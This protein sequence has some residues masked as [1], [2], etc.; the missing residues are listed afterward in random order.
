MDPVQSE[1]RKE[2]QLERIVYFSDAVFAIAITLLTLEIKIPEIRENISDRALGKALVELLPK[3]AGF[4]FSYLMIGLYWSVHHRIFGY[5]THP[6]PKLLRLNLFFLFFI[7]LMPFSTGFYGDYMGGELFTAQLKIPMT[8][9]AL[10]LTFVG[11]SN[12]FLWSYISNPKNKLI[13][14]P[15]DPYTLHMS[16]ARS[17]IVPGI[18]LCMLPIAYLTNTLFAVFVPA[19]IPLAMKIAHGKISKKYHPHSKSK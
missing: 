9:Y 11:I 8:F 17:L 19:L 14:R 4:I 1:I 5:V 3:F 7:V 18:T 10:N 16:K 15:I 6:T 2:F 13:E 12:Y